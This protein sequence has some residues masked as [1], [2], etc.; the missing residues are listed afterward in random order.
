MHTQNQPLGFTLPEMMVAVAILG[1][2]AAIAAPS[3]TDMLER[4]RLVSATE[5]IMSDLRWARSEAIKRNTNIT[6]TFTDGSPWAYEINTAADPVALPIV[7][8]P[9]DTS[10]KAVCSSAVNDFADITLAGSDTT[11]NPVRGTAGN[12]TITLTS[13][14]GNAL[15][16]VVSTLGRVRICSQS[17]HVGGYDAC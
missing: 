11:F 1:I 17:G 6:V 5:T 16:V 14:N 12:G 13:A 4:R 7:C 8:P 15:N 2:L 9:P 3:F 10:L